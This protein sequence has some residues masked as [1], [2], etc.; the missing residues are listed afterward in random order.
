[1]PTD[2]EEKLVHYLTDVYSI[3]RQ[4]LA[5][6][7]TAPEIAG[8][9]SLAEAFRDH[10]RETE[11]QAEAIEERLEAHGASPAR[12]KDAVMYAGGKGQLL[13]ARVQ[14]DT[15]GKLL[16]HA[17]SF[18]AFEW[19]AYDM[20]V[21]MAE[22]AGDPETARVARTIREQELAMRERLAAG[23]DEA[24]DASIR[25]RGEDDLKDLVRTHLADAH[26]LESQSEK[27]LER[28]TDLAGSPEIA[29]VYREHLAET[30][31]QA[32][33]LEARL[34]ALGGDPSTFK[35]G[36]LRLG[37]LQWGLFFQAQS[38]TPGKLA[39][40]AYA[41]EHLEVAGYEL[42]RRVAER[43]GDE[44]TARLAAAIADEERAAADRI[45]G[46]F[47]RAFEVS[48]AT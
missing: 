23:F 7:K 4:A 30:R 3:E 20:L 37:A 41:V 28:S 16:A 10:Y 17:H 33:R 27:L 26:A 43:A 31:D 45:A 15:P 1:M 40:F 8:P 47:D 35:D 18:E 48:L 42:L 2:H 11:L 19:A 5:Q 13:F 46:A 12:L 22:R 6:L 21:R 14:P 32:G 34:D 38:D 9:P 24:A 44:E 36:A 25:D 39:V 29:A